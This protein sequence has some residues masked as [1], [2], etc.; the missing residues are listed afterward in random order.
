MLCYL[1]GGGMG[2]VY[3]P[4]ISGTQSLSSSLAEMEERLKIE[5]YSSLAIQFLSSL[6]DSFTNAVSLKTSHPLLT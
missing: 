4:S 2:E 3:H 1:I 5:P 6:Y